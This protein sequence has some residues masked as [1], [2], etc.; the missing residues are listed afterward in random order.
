MGKVK[1]TLTDTVAPIALG[2]MPIE[3]GTAAA[4]PPKPA[5]IV[6]GRDDANKAH[7]SWFLAA[8]VELAERA[9]GYMRLRALRVTTDEHRAAALQLAAGRIFESGRGFVP[10]CKEAA[11]TALQGFEGSFEPP[12]PVEP[13]PEP[14]ITVSAVPATWADIGVGSAVLASSGPDEGWWP[15]VIVEDRGEGLFVVRW[16]DYDDEPSFVR[17]GV[18]LGLL[19]P[20]AAAQI[21]DAETPAA[22]PDSAPA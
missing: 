11:Y 2:T 14:V 7:A 17:R 21:V 1:A 3:T 5:I 16:Q 12:L 13:E 20:S 18:D 9:A 6:F 4:P 19:P 10:F 22:E 15:S 8:D